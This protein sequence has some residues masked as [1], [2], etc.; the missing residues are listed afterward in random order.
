MSQF[1]QTIA[2]ALADVRGARE[3]GRLHASA[4][5]SIRRW[6]E[7]PE[8]IDYRDEVIVH[9]AR[10]DW[11]LLD[12]LFHC[13]LPFGT[14]GRR[15]R[16]HPIGTNAIN[17]RTVGETIQGLVEFLC[18]EIGVSGL[19]T[20]AVAFDTRHNSRRFANLA[21]E[22]LTAAGFTV[23]FL[24]EPRPTPELALTVRRKGCLCGVMVSASHNPPE[25]NAV[26]IFWSN[27]GQILPFEAEGV[28]SHAAA[29]AAIPRTDFAQGLLIGRI[30]P[31][32][33]ELDRVYV[34]E[35][36]HNRVPGPRDLRI[37]FTPLHGV[38][39][40]SVPAVLERDGFREIA[41]FGP[42]APPDGD[43]PNVPRHVANPES[44]DVFDGPI[45]QAMQTGTDLILATD[46]DAD[47]LG[48]AA[49]RVPEG[50][51]IPLDGNQIAVLLCEFV[52]RHREASG[53]LS[54]EDF[55][56]KTIV[57]TGM[58]D[59]L[60]RSKGVRTFDVLTG[61]K[62]IGEIIDR[63]GPANFVFA[64]EEAHGY[65][66]G[67]HVRDKDG[68]VA[69]LLIAELAAEL[70]AQGQTLLQHLDRLYETYGVHRER[71][72][73][74]NLPGL[75]GARR[76]QQIMDD[77]RGR[78]PARIAGMPVRQVRDYLADRITWTDGS[79]GPL[80][81][82]HGDVLVFELAADGN[83]VAVRPSGTEPKIKF[84]FFAHEPPGPE[85]LAQVKQRLQQ[86]LGMMEA[87]LASPAQ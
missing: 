39:L 78:P 15:G 57:T 13:D 25:D 27:G 29:V 50:E 45:E 56:V 60:A 38:G 32:R 10:R 68:G 40:S 3:A 52:L 23:W 63:E 64:A 48:V 73:S 24:D 53:R 77:L 70:R 7:Q 83:R 37:L 42:H 82:P 55:I 11:A 33:E 46:P 28:A 54:A 71:T 80:N 67:T 20:A 18:E 9:I 66:A 87:E 35:I 61:F 21:A 59:G 58:L 51:F 47:R 22:V 74:V 72:T 84:Y 1:G 41:V 85:P 34:E 30:I 76:R 6:L 75:D 4:A 79:Q 2:A 62:W 36:L 19:L 26:K 8:Y 17:D 49:R 44:A 14:A 5:A 65:L 69:A 31:C 81:G 86:R 16:M 12:E 43:F